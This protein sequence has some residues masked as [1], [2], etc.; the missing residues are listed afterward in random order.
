MSKD[1]FIDINSLPI[2]D[3]E[4]LPKSLRIENY[5]TEV[6]DIRMNTLDDEVSIRYKDSNK[7]IQIE[8]LLRA[9]RNANLPTSINHINELFRSS[10]V[11]KYNP[12]FDY[13][14]EASK[15]WNLNKA[16]EID[17]L[18]SYIIATD[19]D[20]GIDYQKRVGYIF[21]KWLV[22]MIACII[23]NRPNE[24][25]LTIV[26]EGV[27]GVGKSYLLRSLSNDI[28]ERI[29]TVDDFLK[30]I[31]NLTKAST[32]FPLILFEEM[33]GLKTTTDINIFKAVVSKPDVIYVKNRRKVKAQRIASFMAT[34]DANNFIF[35][36][37]GSRRY[38]VI[39]VDKIDFEEY[40]KT[41]DFEMIIAEAAFLYNSSR[42]RFD[43]V[44]NQ[45]DFQNFEI[46][47]R[48]FIKQS[49]LMFWI[50][51]Y[52]DKSAENDEDVEYLQASAIQEL[53]IQKGIPK[54]L[55]SK[56]T[57]Q[58]I[59]LTLKALGFSP[60][61]YTKRIDGK[62]KSRCYCIKQKE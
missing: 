53:L 27:Q 47:N 28:L 51:K 13:I 62:P 18:C 3:D 19:F 16:S 45:T 54:E 58:E 26:S 35:D 34:A 50:N 9:L 20:D 15:R 32:M 37:A 42:K 52:L 39:Q 33:V 60:L 38:G 44:F 5:I 56:I 12:L 17:K 31:K 40:T 46:Y 49:N 48:R 25:M 11:E 4:K 22:S 8:D 43:Y 41:V 7:E 10:F 59:G 57:P 1:R 24:V 30:D 21:K 23:E 29:D 36:I 6:F 2:S 61:P 55:E 14:Q